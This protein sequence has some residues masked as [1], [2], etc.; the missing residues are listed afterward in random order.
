MDRCK[1]RKIKFLSSPFDIDSIRLLNKLKLK[2]F[3]IPSGE[4]NNIPYLRY[5]GSLKKNNTINWNE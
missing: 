3:K 5:L 2:I 1:K 4:I